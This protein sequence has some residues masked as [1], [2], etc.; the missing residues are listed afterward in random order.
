MIIS[1]D[2]GIRNLGFVKWDKEIICMGVI[3]LHELYKGTDYALMAKKLID[4]GF[5]KGAEWILVERQ[6]S[7]RMKIL[8]C[9]IRC[10][11]W[12]KT[13]MISPQSVK[14]YFKSGTKKHSTNKK[15]AKEFLYL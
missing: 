10:F 3:D 1:I 4:T 13:V 14:R 5:F 2:I 15:K 8:A 9:S 7:S 12:D 11:F 6:M